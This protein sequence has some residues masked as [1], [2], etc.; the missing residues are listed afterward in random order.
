[1]SRGRMCLCIVMSFV[2]GMVT[3]ALAC[4]ASCD[5]PPNTAVATGGCPA[6]CSCGC[7]CTHPAT[8][9]VFCYHCPSG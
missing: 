8:P 7:D 9:A 3:P 4:I 6:G 1:M 2:L 5:C